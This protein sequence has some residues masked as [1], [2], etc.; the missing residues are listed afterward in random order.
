MPLANDKKY[1][2]TQEYL[3]SLMTYDPETTI[4]E[5]EQMIS[6][7]YH[8]DEIARIILFEF[9][10]FESDAEI[11]ANLGHTHVQKAYRAADR[12]VAISKPNELAPYKSHPFE[13]HLKFSRICSQCGCAKSSPIHQE[14]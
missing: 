11:K 12:I 5:G 7:G 14:R 10:I 4:R 2:L 6:S 8:C 3:K 9:S 1:N 13:G